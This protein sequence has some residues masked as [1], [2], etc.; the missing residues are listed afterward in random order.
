MVCGV[1]S[2]AVGVATSFF[3]QNRLRA[4]YPEIAARIAP[5]LLRKSLTTH[6]AGLRFLLRRQY[7][8]LN[9]KGFVRFCDFYLVL[10]LAFLVTFAAFVVCSVYGLF[11]R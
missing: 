7:R 1:V 9:R 6:F 5:G 11:G 10:M 3:Y 4:F 2:C 8:S